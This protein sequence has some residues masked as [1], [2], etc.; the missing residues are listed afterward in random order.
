MNERAAV[1][2][3]LAPQNFHNVRPGGDRV[4]GAETHACGNQS[5]SQRF[6]ASHHH[7]LPGFALALDEFKSLQH[8]AQRVAVTGMEGGQRVVQHAHVFAAEALANKLFQ[9]GHI[10]IEHLGHQT[11]S[12]NILPLVLRRPANRLD[13]QTRNRNSEMMIFLL[14]F[15]LGLHVVRIVKHDAALLERID[16]LFV[17]VLV[18]GEQH[19]GVVPGAEHFA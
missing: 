3:Q 14:P 16:V 8:I 4:A 13:R 6:I 2:G 18:K 19:V 12:K 1:F 7:L 9:F 11:Q 17:G 5:E 10:Q 15:G